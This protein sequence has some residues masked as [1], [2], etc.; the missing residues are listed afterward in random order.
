MKKI[1]YLFSALA[2]MA[3]FTACDEKE[4]PDAGL[5]L[6]NIVLDGF[7]VYGEA[8]GTDKVLAENAMAAGSNEVEK[9]VR[10]GMYEKYVWLEANKDFSL[11]EN[12]AGNKVYYGANLAEV[13]YGYDENDKNCKNYAD[14]PNMIIQQGLLVVGEDAPAMQVK[15]TGLYHIVL[16]NNANGDLKEGAQIIVQ[17][18]DWGVRGAMNGWGF[19][20]G[21][22]KNENGVITYTW[23]DQDM[24][25]NGEFKFA[26]CHGWKINL[27]AD[28]I[29]KAEV[30]LGHD[31]EGKLN[32]NAN[33]NLK[34]GEKAGLYKI[35]LTYTC[36]AGALADSFSYTV[37]LTK[38]STIPT[39]CYMTGT[40]FGAWTWGA[41]GIVS[42]TPVHSHGGHF[43]AVR[44]L[45][46]NQGIKFSTINVKDDWS[47]AFGGLTTNTGF[48]NDNDGNAVV[49][50]NGIY[51][52]YVNLVDN[53][54]T[55]EPA[56]VYGIGDAYGSWDAAVEANLFAAAEQK[57][58]GV[59][60]AAGNLR[61]YA[62]A[63]STVT[64]V[65]W[66]QMEFN[67]FDGKIEYR[68]GG[69][70][71]AAVPVTAGQTV[72]LDFNAGTGSIQ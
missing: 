36:K 2:L 52:I 63:P 61:M 51:M 10:T 12:N 67:I 32:N 45:E 53:A 3:G 30:S 59:T 7:Y 28:G 1:F 23:V 33:N 14:N 4:G 34:A 41:E 72:T 39:E 62:A 38:E 25:A 46:A 9:K 69:N 22:V 66:W 24:P 40:A 57:L 19:T 50:E 58:S 42:L 68:A 13:N 43:W 31:D 27:D 48:E 6:D 54:L 8:T 60:A 71:Q 70:D 49:A 18:A 56:K 16:D 17:K 21:E 44:Y 35:V 29:V 55:I 20:K 5:D 11:I 15:E 37:E 47:K 65:D 26:S 64:G